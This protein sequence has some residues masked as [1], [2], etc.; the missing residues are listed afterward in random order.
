MA[1]LD[2]VFWEFAGAFAGA[3][4]DA[5]PICFPEM[6]RRESL[7]LTHDSLKHVDEYA[8]GMTHK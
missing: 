4:A 2:E 5:K 3:F 7:D 1:E 6:L 8:L